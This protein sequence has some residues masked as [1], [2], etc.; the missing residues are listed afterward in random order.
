MVCQSNLELVDVL[1]KICP[2]NT[3]SDIEKSKNEIIK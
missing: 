3:K 1:P 2:S